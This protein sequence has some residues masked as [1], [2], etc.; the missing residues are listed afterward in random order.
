MRIL[1]STDD[2]GGFKDT[3]SQT[4]PQPKE[5]KQFNEQ[6][7]KNRIQKLIVHNRSTKKIVIT[8]RANGDIN[9]YDLNN[10]YGLINTINN[11]LKDI[12]DQYIALFVINGLIISVSQQGKLL[13]ID[14]S[15]IFDKSINSTNFEIKGPIS[16]FIPHPKHFG[17]FAY[18]GDEND[19]KIIK[20]FEKSSTSKEIISNK[21]DSKILFQGKNVKNDKLDLRV[22]IWITGI[23][24]INL[25]NHTDS[26]WEFLT[27]TKYGQ[28]RRYNTSHGRKPILDKKISENPIL[29]IAST[30]NEGE[31]ICSDNKTTTAL[32]NASK[33]NL[34][35]KY[36][37]AVGAVQDLYTD[38]GANLLITGGLDRYVRVFNIETRETIGKIFVGSKIS[39]VWL[40]DDEK[41]EIEQPIDEKEQKIAAKKK[42]LREIEE[43]EDED[44]VWNQL[45][46]LETKSK[47]RKI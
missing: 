8:A 16:S 37:G 9:F 20:L 7:L 34:I 39:Q 14:E 12:K 5:I 28:I 40:L 42:K 29:N 47:K 32:F 19:V 11:G 21:I 18:G 46:Q 25:D 10:E 2:S 38:I 45:D 17:I 35:A 31:I 1:A 3:S 22:K 43:N 33:G 26:K 44:E 30:S 6:G 24:F 27:T 13:I 23:I 41:V 15:T 36:K 4:A